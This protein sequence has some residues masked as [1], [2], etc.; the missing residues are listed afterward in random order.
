VTHVSSWDWEPDPRLVAHLA[1]TLQSKVSV[2]AAGS[3]RLSD[4]W[5]ALAGLGRMISATRGVNDDVIE[6]LTETVGELRRMVMRDE[7]ALPVLAETLDMLAG[8]HR[9]TRRLE[10]ALPLVEEHLTI[11][12]SQLAANPGPEER[13]MC[14]RALDGF[15]RIL[16]L[17]KRHHEA[18]V[19]FRE[20]IALAR[21][22]K[23]AGLPVERELANY[24]SFLSWC[25]SDLD[26]Q[27][28]ALA[29]AEE[30]VDLEARLRLTD[31]L[32]A[33]AR[34]AEALYDLSRCLAVL[35]RWRAAASTAQ[36][37]VTLYR[38]QL[39]GDESVSV[40]YDLADALNRL[41]YCAEGAE[42][43]PDAEAACRAE[44]ALRRELPDR[45]E[46]RN[47]VDLALA[48]RDLAWLLWRRPGRSPEAAPLAW[49]A[50]EL[51]R[52]LAHAS[53]LGGH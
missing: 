24:L 48:L 2:L 35:E 28:E 17:L 5:E 52:T 23:S 47:A 50:A 8:V 38:Q 11:R 49:E 7:A 34:L 44:V 37:A 45:D 51:F 29:A 26:R 22:A 42:Q 40:R 39:A 16:N 14:A 32:G 6:A 4:V 46:A 25:L 10:A 21:E 27:E 15:G 33:P 3:G 13:R 31:P 1:S 9:M 36:E 19:A 30:R 43:W 12:R 53:Q 18:L 41:G 20:A